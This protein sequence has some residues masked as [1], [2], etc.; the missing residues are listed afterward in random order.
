MIQ[1]N[2]LSIT[3]DDKYMAIN[4]QVQNL[5]YYKDVYID[6]I[7]FDTHET[8]SETGP[9]SKAVVVYQANSSEKKKQVNVAWDV[10]TLKNTLFFV[11]VYT[12]GDPDGS[13]PCGMK[14]SVVLGIAYNKYPIY[15]SII[16]HIKTL[17]GCTP[18]YDFVNFFLKLKAFEISLKTGNYTKAVEF[19]KK[20]YTGT[21]TVS[22]HKCG[23]YD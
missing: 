3:Q 2:D 10:D 4:V 15:N 6:S 14:N 5:S 12:K 16:K 1:F 7:V 23:C 17:D 19:W 21:Q 9:S 18:A 20:F 22:T 11:Y 8:Y 13:T